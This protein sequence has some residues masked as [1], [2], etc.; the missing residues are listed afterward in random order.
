MTNNKTAFGKMTPHSKTSALLKKSAKRSFHCHYYSTAAALLQ[1]S[2]P[3]LHLSA[4]FTFSS[5]VS[6]MRRFCGFKSR[7]SILL[8]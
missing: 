7:C 2:V 3:A 8:E 4:V 6:L 5:P 1:L